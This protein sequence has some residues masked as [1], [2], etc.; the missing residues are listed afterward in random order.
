VFKTRIVKRL[1]V[2]AAVSC[3][4]IGAF[5]GYA[6][7]DSQNHQQTLR[8]NVVKKLA[9][10]TSTALVTTTLSSYVLFSA[11][12][13]PVPASG[14]YRVLVRFQG[15][16]AC[17]ANSWCSARIVVDGVLANPK[18]GSDFA[19][20]SPGGETWQSLEMERVSDVI[21][22]TGSVRNVTVQVDTAV[23]GG[24]SWRMDDWTVT[25]ELFKA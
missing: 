16:S 12:T 8:A 11:L 24:G 23:V 10:Q 9:V 22:G 17:S 4:G 7:S 15:E 6:F 21:A 5:A 3:L 13:I 19:F 2:L 25:A 1:G 20:D 18:S 14:N